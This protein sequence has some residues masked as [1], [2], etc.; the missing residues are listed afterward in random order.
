VP[1]MRRGQ[2]LNKQLAHSPPREMTLPLSHTHTCKHA[3]A[4]TH[5]NTKT[6]TCTYAH[7]HTH[8]HTH[9][10]I[11]AHT[12]TLCLSHTSTRTHRVCMCIFVCVDLS[13][14]SQRTAF[15]TLIEQHSGTQCGTQKGDWITIQHSEKDTRQ[16]TT[17]RR[18]KVLPVA[19][20]VS[21]Y[22]IQ[23]QSAWYLFNGKWQKRPNELDYRLRFEIEAMTL[24]MQ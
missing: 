15:T 20:G 6:H 10:N 8:T 9:I 24:Q 22:H 21:F 19:S 11:H 12:H 4:D 5:T 1:R 2:P 16:S 3:H 23:S 7:T 14:R 18:D 13:P 17:H